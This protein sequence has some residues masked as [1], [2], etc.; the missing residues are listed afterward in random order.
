L[1]P[2]NPTIP[3]N[4][5]Q[6]FNAAYVASL[7]TPVQALFTFESIG[8]PGVLTL[9]GIMPFPQYL[10][11]FQSLIARGYG[12]FLLSVGI[13]GDPYSVFSTLAAIGETWVPNATQIPLGLSGQYS[14]PGVTPEPGYSLGAYPTTLPAGWITVPPMAQLLAPGANVSALLAAWYPPFNPPTPAAPAPPAP[15]DPVGAQMTGT[16]DYYNAPGAIETTYPN[17]S[18]Y[19]DSRGTFIHNV[20]ATPFGTVSYWSLLAA[21]FPGFRITLPVTTDV[22]DSL[23]ALV[24]INGATPEKLAVIQTNA[25]A[26]NS[27]GVNVTKTLTAA[28][29]SVPALLTAMQALYTAQS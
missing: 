14:L 20:V 29:V 19:T 25:Q 24:S 1:N 8:N 11:Q 22:N 27:S 12:A 7:P 2:T 23:A 10:A 28:G 17:G 26:Y 13:G 5:Q 9:V 6:A 3:V 4:V 18:E 15:T 21:A 16:S